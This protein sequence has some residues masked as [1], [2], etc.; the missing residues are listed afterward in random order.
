MV[1]FKYRRRKYKRNVDLG[2]DPFCHEC[3]SH[4]LNVSGYPRTKVD[5]KSINVMRHVHCT[6]TGENPEVVMHLCDNR[7][8]INPK[9][10]QGG[11]HMENMRDMAAKGRA[12]SGGVKLTEVD[13]SWIKAWLRAGYSHLK[14][15]K[16]FGVSGQHVGRISS[17]KTWRNVE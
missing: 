6:S 9:H 10:L 17:G 7:L 12:G 2:I 11:T 4:S 13:V 5:G 1:K 15:G 16:A 14:I 3:T 8:C